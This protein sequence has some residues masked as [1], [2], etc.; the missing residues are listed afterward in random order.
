VT[1]ELISSATETLNLGRAL[2]QELE[3]AAHEEQRDVTN[4]GRLLIREGLDER[5]KAALSDI[6]VRV[7]PR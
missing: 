4:L 6:A 3:R 5:R 1:D 2:K 7:G